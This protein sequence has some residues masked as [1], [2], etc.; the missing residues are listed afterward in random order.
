MK[1]RGRSCM[2]NEFL[3]LG[4]KKYTYKIFVKKIFFC[5]TKIYFVI[6]VNKRNLY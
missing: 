2:T 6:I 4:P 3:E 5:Y 1:K